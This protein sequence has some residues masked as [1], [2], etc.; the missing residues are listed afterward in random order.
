MAEKTYIKGVYI[1]TISTQYG[2][3]LKVS[4]KWADFVE[5][6][7]PLVNES[8]YLNIDVC[9]M[10]EPKNGNTHYAVL[11]TWKKEKDLPTNVPGDEGY[12]NDDPDG[13][14]F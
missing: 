6:N 10:K 2:D 9:K 13:L 11:N 5:Q 14:P 12:N 4:I 3:M 7:R 1:K 8:G